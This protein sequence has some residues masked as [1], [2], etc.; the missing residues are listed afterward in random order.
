MS[1]Q[2]T[3]D[4]VIL[5]VLEH[6]G[7][8]LPVGVVGQAV[9]FTLRAPAQTGRNLCN[10][11]G[12]VPGCLGPTGPTYF[13]CWGRCCILVTSDP[14]ILGVLECLG[15]KHGSSNMCLCVHMCAHTHTHFE[16]S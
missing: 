12:G 10:W 15:V 16:K 9:Q 5:G 14:M 11:S 8:E 1:A 13:W 4:P 3:Y 6:L 7:V 2:R